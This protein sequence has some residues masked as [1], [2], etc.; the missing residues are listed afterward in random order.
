MPESAKRR[1][2]ANRIEFWAMVTELC[3]TPALKQATRSVS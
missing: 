1:A 2:T 3:R